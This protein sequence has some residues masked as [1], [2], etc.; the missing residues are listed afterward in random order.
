M[1][2]AV[3][4]FLAVLLGII[5][6]ID[7]LQAQTVGQWQSF[8]SLN[9]ARVFTAY[10]SGFLVA[11]TGGIIYVDPSS[12]QA[13]PWL[14]LDDGLHKGL[15]PTSML[16]VAS[17]QYLF[18]GYEDGM[19][20]RY[21]LEDDQLIKVNDIFR[22]TRNS[23][24]SITA[25]KQDPSNDDRLWLATAFGLVAYR[26]EGNFVETT[27]N[28]F[29]P[30]DQ[31]SAV[32]EIDF[33]DNRVYVLKSD[34]L[35]TADLSDFE[36]LSL[37][38]EWQRLP[39]TMGVSSTLT[40][41]AVID[42]QL[43]LGSASALF[44]SSIS[45]MQ[46]EI[47]DNS[48]V[49][50]IATIEG[51]NEYSV[52]ARQSA[53]SDLSKVL[54]YQAQDLQRAINIDGDL[55]V[56]SMAITPNS[57]FL[58][59]N[60]ASVQRID[61]S[62]ATVIGYA[63]QGPS[64]NFF[65]G[66][67]IDSEQALL[68]SGTTGQPQADEPAARSR[69]FV[70]YD[71]IENQWQ[72]FN[73]RTTPEL[74][75]LDFQ[76]AFRVTKFEGDYFIGSWGKGILRYNRSASTFKVYGFEDG[77]VGVS[78]GNYNVTHG[79]DV[80]PQGRLW[81]TGFFSPRPLQY[82]NQAEDRWISHPYVSPSNSSDSYRDFL[83]DRN[84]YHWIEMR[85]IAGTGLLVVDPADPLSSED[86]RAIRLTADPN[87]GNLPDLSVNAVIQDLNGEIWVGTASGIA[88]FMFPDFI[89]DGGR[90]ERT[91]QPL[92]NADTTA[93]R[94]FLLPE[95]NVSV[96]QVDGANTKWVGTPS[97][98]L[99]QLN[100]EGS[101]VLNHFTAENSPLLSNAIIDLAYEPEQGDLFVAT[102]K[103]LMAFRTA[104]LAAKSDQKN[105]SVYPNPYSYSDYQGVVT[106]EGMAERS[107][108]KVLTVDGVLLD[109]FEVRGARAQWL[110]R[111]KDG[112]ELATGIYVIAA[113]DRNGGST[114]TTKLIVVR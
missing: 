27:I 49:I 45:N 15:N 106:I 59:T 6:C 72:A 74:N 68:I 23:L 78:G 62:T 89:L 10:E 100:E 29:N 47:L 107:L 69:G 92:L 39:I 64:S 32:L 25:I 58:A 28:R 70:V 9:D 4:C 80:D 75:T 88:K 114:R 5:G 105:L 46:W 31:Q 48:P 84:G 12:D 73:K 1:Q 26:I 56:V 104:S 50:Q 61:R 110:P 111:R 76:S 43:V 22:S 86:D 103:G 109:E 83:I 99:W 16:W 33:Y 53:N 52:L 94:P 77:L 34:G 20:D 44:A 13:E 41:F 18:V 113:I 19:I 97:D 14:S 108:I 102:D 3:R 96:M 63:V 2:I 11:T 35:Y 51:G 7:L 37:P 90:A 67:F 40:D 95:I 98:G 55:Q 30:S 93:D 91:A 85:S 101:R 54:L 21:S 38:S 60:N 42:Q 82:F 112:G 57:I 24:K 17:K 81:A 87:T 71:L 36:L 79:L 66:L 8:L 65:D